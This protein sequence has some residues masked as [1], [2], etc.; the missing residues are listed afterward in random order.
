MFIYCPSEPWQEYIEGKIKELSDTV[1]IATANAYLV[2]VMADG[3]NHGDWPWTS[4]IDLVRIT[5]IESP[6]AL[7]DTELK[8]NK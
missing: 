5:L 1:G 4:R 7:N 2:N 8:E 3:L 6:S